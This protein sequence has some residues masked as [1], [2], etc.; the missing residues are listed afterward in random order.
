RPRPRYRLDVDLET[1]L[2][3]EQPPACL[4][5]DCRQRRRRVIRHPR[6]VHSR[7]R[8]RLLPVRRPQQRLRGPVRCQADPGP[9]RR[10]ALRAHRQPA[11]VSCL[12]VRP[13]RQPVT[14]VGRHRQAGVVLP[15]PPDDA[16]KHSYS[17]RSLV[18]L[19]PALI[20]SAACT[21]IA[22]GLLEWKNAEILPAA[23]IL[24]ACYTLTYLAYQAVSLP[25]NFT[26]R[27]FD[28]GAHN[29]IVQS[30]R[31]RHRPDVDIFLPICG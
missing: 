19:T 25:V 5:E 23:A 11:R 9:V 8:P 22:Q 3:P 14:A 27:P 31:P 4:R 28:L 7:H 20:S 24:F 18:H 1:D 17:S 13:P 30:W 21:T 12:G 15:M 29:T 16:E 6:P 10:H 26:G 2:G